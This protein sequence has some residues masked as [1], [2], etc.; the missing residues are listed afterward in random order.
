MIRRLKKDVKLY[1][2]GTRRCKLDDA[3][4]VMVCFDCGRSAE[5][6][7]EKKGFYSLWEK[8]KDNTYVVVGYLCDDCWYLRYNEGR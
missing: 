1:A 2:G 6:N 5:R 7:P 8:E 3:L 4:G